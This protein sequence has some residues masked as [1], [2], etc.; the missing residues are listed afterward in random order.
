MNKLKL[1]LLDILIIGAVVLVLALGVFILTGNSGSNTPSVVAPQNTT[2]TLDF[3]IKDADLSLGEKFQQGAENNAPVWVGIKERF[4]GKIVD[5]KVTPAEKPG[6]D[7]YGGNAVIAK[8]QVLYDITVTIEAP[9]VETESAITSSGTAIRVGEQTAVRGKGFAG[10]GY[11]I[12]L[13]TRN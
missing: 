1:N 8:S 2:A 11:I 7:I 13:T 10:F 5:V 4:E 3:Q 9:A 6:D 12:G